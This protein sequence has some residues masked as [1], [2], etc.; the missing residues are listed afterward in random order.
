LGKARPRQYLGR[1]ALIQYQR[2]PNEDKTVTDIPNDVL[3]AHPQAATHTPVAFRTGNGNEG[4]RLH[5]HVWV[6]NELMDQL[7]LITQAVEI[8]RH[9]TGHSV[10]RFLQRVEP[11]VDSDG[12]AIW[13][14][15]PGGITAYGSAWRISEPR[16][17]QYADMIEYEQDEFIELKNCLDKGSKQWL[18]KRGV[19]V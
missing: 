15:G 16:V 14:E 12:A 6:P 10:R 11:Y 19:R 7:S 4:T 2:N 18:S 8:D 1:A 5:A 13:S 17:I 3:I 9:I